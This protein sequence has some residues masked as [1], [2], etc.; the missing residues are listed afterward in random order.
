VNA[1]TISA[2]LAIVTSGRNQTTTNLLLADLGPMLREQVERRLSLCHLNI[3]LARYD[4]GARQSVNLEYFTDFARTKPE[5]PFQYRIPEYGLLDKRVPIARPRTFEIVFATTTNTR[6][7]AELLS[8][9]AIDAQ[10]LSYWEL[11][12]KRPGYLERF[13][14]TGLLPEATVKR[15]PRQLGIRDR[16]SSSAYLKHRAISFGR[17]LLAYDRE[18]PQ[19][20]TKF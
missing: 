5:G 18:P 7:F 10:L 14:R 9:K 4:Q 6:S 11:R 8:A 17:R 1:E 15:Q 13:V 16:Y 3:V 19:Y 2:S 20:D 12:D